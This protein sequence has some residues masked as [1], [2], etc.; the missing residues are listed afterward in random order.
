MDIRSVFIDAHNIILAFKG[1]C[2]LDLRISLNF[3]RTS[4]GPVLTAKVLRYMISPGSN[5]SRAA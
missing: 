2:S 3:K 1:L 5:M 4:E